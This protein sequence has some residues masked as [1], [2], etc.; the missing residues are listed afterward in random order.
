MHFENALATIR[1]G[2]ALFEHARFTNIE[3]LLH[4]TIITYGRAVVEYIV[5]R[6]ANYLFFRQLK[7]VHHRLI[8]LENREFTVINGKGVGDAFKNPAEELLIVG[9][10][11]YLPIPEARKLASGR[12]TVREL[13]RARN[14]DR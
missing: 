4:M 12:H 7:E 9:S 1:R 10:H 8:A 11:I 14:K 6:S 3:N 13:M 2:D 5:A